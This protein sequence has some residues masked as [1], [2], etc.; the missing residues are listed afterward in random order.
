MGG[1]P[2]EIAVVIVGAG[3]TGLTAAN[4][5]CALGVSCIVLER[6]SAPLDLPRAIV[7]DDEGM[8]TFQVFGI[9]KT[10]IAKAAEG[11]GAR[12]YDD[13]GKCFA[14]TGRGPRN[15]GF[16]KRHFINQPELETELR[17]R[18]EAQS[19][20]AL[21]FSSQVL[22]IVD[23]G[24]GA[25]VSVRDATGAR[26]EIRTQWV[27]ACD[28][29]RS[30]IRERLGI[31][32]SG[33]T[34]K[35]DWIVLDML[36]DPDRSNY[37]KFICSSARPTV[38]V[39]APRGGRRYEFMVLDGETREQVLENAFLADL[40]RP[41]RALESD[42]LVRKTVYTFHARMAERFRTGR[43]LLLGDAAH[44]TP[45]FAGQGMNAGFRD[46]HNVAWKTACV[47]RGGADSNILDS[48]E[49]ERRKPA[50]DMIQLAVTMGNFVMPSDAE[51]IL[52]R[53]LLVKALEPFPN[54]RDYL[55]QMRF[56]PKP[57]YE[58]GL[59]LDM[60]SPVFE[61]SLVGEMIPQPLVAAGQAEALLDE[62]L[63]PGFALIGQSDRA[64]AARSGLESKT[65]LGLPLAKVDLN[66]F[67]RDADGAL[68]ILDGEVAR[69]LLTHRD[70]ILLI[71]PDRYCAMAVFPE[72]LGE[73]LA[74]YERMLAGDGSAKGTV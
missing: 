53:D 56:K 12:Y 44:L 62:Y 35:Q 60:E 43:I 57:K 33:S 30:P 55:I 27:L 18:L 1:Y 63:G 15:Y 17:D 28:G 66:A 67:G 5:L 68:N 31:A 41:Y 73:A 13:A 70:Q 48:Y 51:Q 38:S 52:F 11:D 65:Y 16:A 49:L 59:F 7:L 29:G 42:D 37:S 8:R 36:N 25:V 26:H 46:A 40:L 20:G 9:D 74:R 32:M 2:G 69:P 21:R 54:V 22:D 58:S 6:E 39:P 24:E 19:P 72:M 14:V 45:P 47:L 64:R 10:Y 23:H 34:Y 71:R 3:P 50:W 4:L 61:A